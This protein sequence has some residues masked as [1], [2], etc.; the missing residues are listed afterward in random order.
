M[1]PSEEKKDTLFE[2]TKTLTDMSQRGNLYG[3]LLELKD[4]QIH[5]QTRINELEKQIEETD[6]LNKQKGAKMKNKKITIVLENCRDDIARTILIDTKMNMKKYE[7]V[8]H[9]EFRKKGSRIKVLER[10]KRKEENANRS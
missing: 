10:E 9:L 1:K 2:F 3:R 7:S 4:I 8:N 6:P 5:I